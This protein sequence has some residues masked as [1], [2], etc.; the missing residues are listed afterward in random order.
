MSFHL[1][2]KLITSEMCYRSSEQKQQ[3]AVLYKQGLA[4]NERL[5]L[6]NLNFYK[7]ISHI[8][9]YRKIIEFIQV[10]LHHL[11]DTKR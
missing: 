9:V 7:Y 2:P 8:T 10:P 6:G 5:F 11:S 3:L 4:T 1:V